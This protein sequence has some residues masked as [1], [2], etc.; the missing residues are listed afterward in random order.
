M[1][2]NFVAEFTPAVKDAHSVC[3]V[4]IRAWSVYVDGAS[5]ARGSG[6]LLQL[7]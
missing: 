6:I 4:S 3:Q 7:P 2:A 5:N 1:L